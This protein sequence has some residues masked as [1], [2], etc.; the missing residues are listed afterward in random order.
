MTDQPYLN[1]GR[2]LGSWVWNVSYYVVNPDELFR[3]CRK[4]HVTELYFSINRDVT[5][6]RYCLLYTST[7]RH[8]ASAPHF[9]W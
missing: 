7:R 9:P 3:F 5:D 1:L 8:R 6:A 2:P 4:N